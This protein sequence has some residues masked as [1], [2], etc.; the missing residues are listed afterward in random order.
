MRFIAAL[1]RFSYSIVSNVL[2]I[3]M[4]TL[5]TST[6]QTNIKTL[7]PI[8]NVVAQFNEMSHDVEAR[9]GNKTPKGNKIP[10]Q[11]SVD[12][13]VLTCSCRGC[14]AIHHFKSF[15][16]PKEIIIPVTVKTPDVIDVDNDLSLFKIADITN[17]VIATVP[18]RNKETL[19]VQHF[20]HV[21]LFPMTYIMGADIHRTY[22]AALLVCV[23]MCFD[24]Y[25][26][27]NSEINNIQCDIHCIVFIGKYLSQPN[28]QVLQTLVA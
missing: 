7:I 20:Q 23:D 27:I 24:A 18:V 11:Q 16:T 17:P 5:D 19:W 4:V 22:T 10:T 8:I 1:A 9:D 25:I 26:R 15:K 3:A 14:S 2:L 13:M 6:R 12:A 28:H 21:G